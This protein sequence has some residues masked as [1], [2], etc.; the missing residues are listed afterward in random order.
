MN[1]GNI[2]AIHTEPMAI[3]DTLKLD[4]EYLDFVKQSLSSRTQHIKNNAMA[5]QI[6]FLEQINNGEDTFMRSQIEQHN[7]R[8]DA[9]QRPENSQAPHHDDYHYYAHTASSME[10]AMENTPEYH[11]EFYEQDRFYEQNSAFFRRNTEEFSTDPKNWGQGEMAQPCV[12]SLTPDFGV[13]NSSSCSNI[14]NKRLSNTTT[15]TDQ[16]FFEKNSV[17]LKKLKKLLSPFEFPLIC[18][19]LESIPIPFDESWPDKFNPRQDLLDQLLG[20]LQ[21][22]QKTGQGQIHNLLG[23]VNKLREVAQAGKLTVDSYG[24]SVKEARAARER[25]LRQQNA[26]RQGAGVKQARANVREEAS[27]EQRQKAREALAELKAKL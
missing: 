8:L 14:N 17:E 3:M 22:Y 2:Y 25:S 13:S 21:T 11:E 1:R 24:L 5:A 6:A 4:T 15:T 7:A 27:P 16:D 23:F 26:S 18:S 10:K 19:T 9:L 20:R 12:F